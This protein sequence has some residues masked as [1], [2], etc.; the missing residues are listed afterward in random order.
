MKAVNAAAFTELLRLCVHFP[1]C[2]KKMQRFSAVSNERK[3]Y[4]AM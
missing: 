3:I 1:N 4:F 2:D